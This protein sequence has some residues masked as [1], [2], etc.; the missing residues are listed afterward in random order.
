L[1]DVFITESILM[2]P[3]GGTILDIIPWFSSGIVPII[4]QNVTIYETSDLPNE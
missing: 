2:N 3:V 4:S 1:P